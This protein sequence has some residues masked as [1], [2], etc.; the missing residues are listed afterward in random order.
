MHAGGRRRRSAGG[1][2]DAA[3]QGGGL[4]GARPNRARV[5]VWVRGF[6]QDVERGA[7]NVSW[8]KAQAYRRRRRRTTRSGG[9][10]RISG[11]H[12]RALLR[13]R[14]ANTW[15]RQ[16]PL[17]L[18]KLPSSVAMTHRRRHDGFKAA[19]VLGF[20]RRRAKLEGRLGFG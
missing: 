17:V 14:D 20:R 8:A 18:A 6:H 9:R 19:A 7:V 2:Q 15:H 11:E 16:L 12:V 5:L 13:T 3:M 4:N 10:R 1:E